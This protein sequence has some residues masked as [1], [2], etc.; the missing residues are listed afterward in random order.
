MLRLAMYGYSKS[1]YNQTTE[2]AQVL[3]SNWGDFAFCKGRDAL[4]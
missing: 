3:A 4:P 1:M 2:G